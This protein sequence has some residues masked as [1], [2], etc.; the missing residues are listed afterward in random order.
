[1]FDFVVG[2]GVKTKGESSRNLDE[3]IEISGLVWLARG[4]LPGVNVVLS[5]SSLLIGRMR[6]R[7]SLRKGAEGGRADE[8]AWETKSRVADRCRIPFDIL[9]ASNV[10]MKDEG[11]P[12]N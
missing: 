2:L 11:E 12:G 8:K 10:A 9:A 4:G 6:S 1:M 5:V 7:V 3:F